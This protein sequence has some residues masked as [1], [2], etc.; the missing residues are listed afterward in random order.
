MDDNPLLVAVMR[1]LGASWRAMR[2]YPPN[3]PMALQ[4]AQTI[5]D[6]ID[7]Y[8]QAE[9][10]LKLDVVREGFILRGVEGVFS[11]P[12]VPDLT[13][14]LGLHGVGE[15]HF[16]APPAAEEVV[17]F[18]AAAA[19]RPQDTDARGH[20]QQALTQADVVSIKTVPVVLSKVETPPEIP[21]E[22]A[23]KFLA[24]L[25]A[26]SARLAVWLRSLLASDDEGLTEGIL[27]LA[28]AAED[29]RVFGRTMAHA[30]TELESDDT[31]RLLEAAIGLPPLRHV[32]VEMLANLSD[33]ELVSAIR[34]GR[35]GANLMALSFALAH[36]PVG[37][38]GETLSREMQDALRAA[39]VR[40]ERLVF[41][42]RMVALRRAGTPETSLVDA[43][44]YYVA[45]LGGLQLQPEHV[46]PIQSTLAARRRLDAS[47]VMTLLHL[48]DT[49]DEFPA[50]SRVLGA[51]ARS[52]PRILEERGPELAM[53]VVRRLAA[54]GSELSR[55]WP[56]LQDRL[57]EAMAEACGTQTM[58]AL[59]AMS[60]SDERAANCAKEMMN[61]TGDQAASSLASAALAS[62]HDHA[63]DFAHLVI[64]KRLAEMLA[65]EAVNATEANAARLAALFAEDGGSWS[66]QALASM[67]V[68]PEDRV[69]AEV[70]RGLATA[71][72]PAMVQFMP[73]LLRDPSSVTSGIAIRVLARN[74]S[75]EAAALLGQRLVEIDNERDL[76]A[77]R[78]IIS[79][80]VNFDFDS[81]MTALAQAAEHGTSLKRWRAELK[82]LAA[83]A[84][85]VIETRRGA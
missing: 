27:L 65:P 8:L 56:E 75:E 11:A 78:E 62:D 22:E 57:G 67:T 29:I 71:G 3:S 13:D 37:E 58:A 32:L 18:M 74:A 44:G 77:A 33:V 10:S 7:E 23:D 70:A 72:G 35:F 42:A 38:R 46:A 55:P 52:V 53:F 14:T 63:M 82:R 34:G 43:N 66:V 25:A 60:S 5:C 17:A 47:T 61:I 16:V 28:S 85:A 45:L 48:L 76:P 73:Q 21:E 24:E 6:A 30:F 15:L 20:L 4:A 39:E 51:L 49:A 41:L 79:L 54:Q 31:D 19:Q 40:E 50:Y 68:R 83:D 81:A 64:G 2:L 1:S 84:L 12:G 9:P 69:R 26:D 59:L 36:L 80:L